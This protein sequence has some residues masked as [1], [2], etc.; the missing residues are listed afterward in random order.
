M[1]NI[2]IQ[3]KKKLKELIHYC[4][5]SESIFLLVISP[6]VGCGVGFGAL[7]FRWLIDL[8]KFIFFEE[9]LYLLH[10]MGPYYVIIIPAI[11]GL[12]IGP[13]IYFFA[14]EVR[15]AGVPEVMLAVSMEG[16]KI[17][18]RVALIKTIVTSICISSGGS[19]GREGPI[20]QIGSAI[21]STLGQ[22]FNFSEEKTRMLLAC[23]AAGGIAATFNAPLAG[24]FFALEVILRQYGLRYF[25]SVVL[26]SV[27][28]TVVSRYFFGDYPAFKV[29]TYQ[30]LSIWEIPLYVIFGFLAAGAALLFVKVLYK[31]D[32]FFIYIKIP[33]YIKPAIGGLLVGLIGFYYPEIFGVGYKTIELTLYGKLAANVVIVLIFAKILA[34]SITLGSGGSGGIFAP[35]LFIGATLGC[36]YGK[37]T[38]LLVPTIAI[39]PGACALVGMGA[40]LSGATHAPISAI[41]IL[42]EITGNYKI[43]LPLMITCVISI[44]ITRMVNRDSI[45]TMKL[46]RRGIDILNVVHIDLMEVTRVEKAMDKDVITVREND[47]V[48]NAGLMIK[49]TGHRGFPVLDE[50]GSLVGMVTRKDI[51]KALADNIAEHSVREIMSKDITVCYPNEN[52]RTA[53]EKLGRRNVGRL[54]VVAADKKDKLIGL[55]TRKNIVS[56]YNQAISEEESE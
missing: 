29:P 34:T 16:G 46:K 50:K 17:R 21:G 23:G 28:A 24:I 8:F 36:A 40:V 7:F 20:V 32:D 35:C 1:N 38:Y 22:F 39:P 45:Y 12:M 48:R 37:I 30:F 55:I 18:P 5:V 15:G 52:L 3:L 2:K 10:F 11:G 44:M 41:L 25:S 51:N 53:L 13:L 14:S 6:L 33:E 31:C 26:S 27:T 42:F 49:S 43:L 47:S 54:P 19:V 4:Q 56:A 9:K